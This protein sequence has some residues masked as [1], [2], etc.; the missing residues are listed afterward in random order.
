MKRILPLITG[1]LLVVSTAFAHEGLRHLMPVPQKIVVHSGS[2][3]IDSTFKIFV[4]G[5]ASGRINSY[6][7]QF[8]NRLRNRTGLFMQQPVI[9]DSERGPQNAP[10]VFRYQATAG[11]PLQLG[12]DE[13]YELDIRS[14]NIRLSAKNDLGILRGMETL[15]QLLSINASGYYFPDVSISDS[16]RFPWRGLMIDVSR[17]F[18]PVDAI[19]R[20]LRAMAAMKMNVFHWHLADDQGFRVES[21][22]FPKLHEMGSDGLYFTQNQ[23][24]DIIKYADNL[25]IR[26]IPEFDVP[27][28]STAWFVGYPEYASAPGPYSI[29]RN[30][31]VFD[32]TFNPAE[33]KTYQFFDVLFREMCELFPDA[34]FH[35]GGDENNGKQWDANPEIQEFMKKN[36]LKDNHELQAYFNKRLLD[37]LT[38][39]NKKMIGWDEILE[40][41]MPTNIV[42]QSWRGRKSLIEA[43]QKG[44]MGLLSNGYYIDLIQSAEFH[45][46]N[47]PIGEDSPLNDK[48][49]KLILGGEATSWA[50]LVTD[51]TVD[52]RIWPRT[53][54]IA[55]RFWSDASVRDVNDMYRR[56]DYI[57]YLLEDAGTLHLKNYE[58]MLRRITNNQDISGLMLLCNLLEPVKI[59]TRH[60]QGKKYTSFSPYSRI[61]DAARPESM[62]SRDFKI[63]VEKFI[64]NS[65]ANAPEP[66]KNQLSTWMNLP[67]R[68]QGIFDNSPIAAEIKPHAQNLEKLADFALQAIKSIEGNTSLVKDVYE[69]GMGLI[70]LAKKPVAQTEL[71]IIP[72]IEKLLNAAA[73]KKI[74]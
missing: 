19:K 39:N 1:L 52:S 48:Q 13:S 24:T 40:P 12:E 64:E 15:Y 35:I 51:E 44:Y 4:E 53:A 22:T 3:I 42:I 54:A 67:L 38:K 71:M 50:E 63:A 68:L 7:T 25:G 26:V 36:S 16:P 21:K 32:P 14:G 30:W 45:Y 65:R 18:L 70:A 23:I 57:S 6:A 43:A 17:H 37:I 20:N 56:L 2:F 41:S 72:A 9:N 8:L 46:L 73:G 66:L 69:K 33:E 28:H 11:Y 29:E 58:M 61:V 62:C 10:C 60:S 5:P 49:K 34:Y 31:G 59:Y 27:G 74:K 47:D 55:E